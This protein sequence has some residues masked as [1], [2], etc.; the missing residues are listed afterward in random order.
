MRR[1]ISSVEEARSLVGQP[2]GASAGILVDQARID[3]FAVATGDNQWIH[4]DVE[5]AASGTF[6]GTIAHG[7]LTL[8]LIAQF[9]SQLYKIDFGT[10][11]L[12]YGS[13]KVRFPCPVKAGSTLTA[14]ATI[15][16]VRSA[17]QGTFITVQFTVTADGEAKP[18][19]VAETI[20]LVIED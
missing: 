5:R 14:S 13:N 7:Y 19:C 2:L 16:E 17:H 18:A 1:L 3:A 20:T 4:V 11:R 12:N 10:A 15:L 8:A 6:G 9:S